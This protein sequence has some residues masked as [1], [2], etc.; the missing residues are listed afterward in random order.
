MQNYFAIEAEVA[1]RQ[2]E[3]E[4]SCAAAA[5][6]APTRPKNGRTHWSHLAS[7]AFAHLRSLAAPRL[8]VASWNSSAVQYAPP[9][10]VEGR[11][12]PV[13]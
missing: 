8:P 7:L 1:H 11:R 2:F 10:T 3:M 6:I 12:A 9:L 5:Q 13:T 4:R